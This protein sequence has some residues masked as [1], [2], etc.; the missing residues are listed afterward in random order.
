MKNLKHNNLGDHANGIMEKVAF[1]LPE[2]K[3]RVA[4]LGC[5]G[6]RWKAKSYHITHVDKRGYEDAVKSDLDEKFPFEDKQ[7]DGTVA[8]ELIEHLE[9]PYHFLRETTRI[10]KN[11]IIITTPTDERWF[12][13]DKY[14]HFHHRIQVPLWLLK[15]YGHDLGWEVTQVEYNNE[16]KE[17]LIVKLEPRDYEEEI[18]EQKLIRKIRNPIDGKIMHHV[19]D[20]DTPAEYEEHPIIKGKRVIVLIPTYNNEALLPIW[21][22]FLY[23][24][25]PQP[26]EY[27]FA[28]NN[29]TDDT[30]ELI[31]KFKRPHKLIRVWFKDKP[32]GKGE[33]P[34]NT[35]AHIRQLLLTYARNSDCDYAIFLDTDLFPISTNLIEHITNWNADIVGGKYM[36]FFPDG[37]M[38]ASY[39]HSTKTK[40]WYT[41]KGKTSL[42][43]EEV[44]CTSGGCLCLS[45]KIIQDRNINF[46]PI[47]DRML[48]SEDFGYCILAAKHGYKTYL[49][50][51]L[52]LRHFCSSDRTVTSWTLGADG[53]MAPFSYNREEKG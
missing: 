7:F 27:V 9:N 18:K 14:K 13:E 40:G 23:K 22:N 51:M 52:D 36:R 37:L 21:F 33:S 41:L 25:N 8:I 42:P 3:Q 17:I 32:I 15:C 20:P 35:I 24:L 39:W 49:D 19:G 53:K 26:T 47:K 44:A 1:M 48:T 16:S 31:R 50:S 12:S 6:F 11:W 4:D 28:E 29:S 5:G 38:I 45:K 2:G 46:F 10:S 43:F 30:L 34:Y